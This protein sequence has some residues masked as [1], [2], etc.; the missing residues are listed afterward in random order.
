MRE[1]DSE[2]VGERKG[3]R[4]M[5]KAGFKLDRKHRATSTTA[6]TDE[7]L[8][9]EREQVVRN[10]TTLVFPKRDELLAPTGHHNH[11]HHHFGFSAA[12]IFLFFHHCRNRKTPEITSTVPLTKMNL[13]A[14]IPALKLDLLR[15][16]VANSL[17]TFC[18]K[19]IAL[20]LYTISAGTA[21]PSMRIFDAQALLPG[22]YPHLQTRKGNF[23]HHQHRVC[24]EYNGAC[25]VCYPP[26]GNH[27]QVCR[28]PRNSI[29]ANA[30][31]GLSRIS[32]QTKPASRDDGQLPY[33]FD[34]A[35]GAGYAVYTIGLAGFGPVFVYGPEFV[36][37]HFQRTGTATIALLSLGG[38]VSNAVDSAL[39]N[40]GVVV[41]AGNE[42][43]IDTRLKSRRRLSPKPK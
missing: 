5:F 38:G 4:G 40:F 27:R 14:I 9:T 42:D 19:P 23:G 1:G 22:K 31:R 11:L 10:R 26:V 32:S 2:W 29:S 18:P 35:S 16:L 34:K 7:F 24:L 20:T 21:F 28:R 37:I 43:V 15:N 25:V 12:Y 33:T 41:A 17:T 30:P 6:D 3:S 36:A 13:N 39:V 8:R